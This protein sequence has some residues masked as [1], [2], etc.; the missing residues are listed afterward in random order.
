MPGPESGLPHSREYR[1]MS[2]F[3]RLL[4]IAIAAGTLLVISLR[5]A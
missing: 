3:T 2:F 5:A 1:D 4:F